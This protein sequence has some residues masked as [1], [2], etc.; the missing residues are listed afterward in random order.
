LA[1]VSEGWPPA[2]LD[3]REPKVKQ[4]QEPGGRAARGLSW[5][6]RWMLAKGLPEP[7]EPPFV[8]ELFNA[9]QR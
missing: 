8:R 2:G 9:V 5:L 3:L 7:A 6:H 4:T 1:G